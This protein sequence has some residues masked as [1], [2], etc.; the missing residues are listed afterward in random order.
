M[1]KSPNHSYKTSIE[2]KNYLK[3]GT[4]I[5]TCTNEG[6]IQKDTP[7]ISAT[8]AIIYG[9]EG[10]STKI[11]GDGLVISYMIDHIAL[12]E[13]VKVSGH[14]VELGFIIGAKHLVN[15]SLLKEDGTANANVVKATLITISEDSVNSESKYVGAQ[16]KITGIWDGTIDIEGTQTDIKDVKFYI[17]GFIIDVNGV[18][19]LNSNGSS[20][21]A[22]LFSYND[23]SVD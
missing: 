7:L 14:S 9:F 20:S 3:S 5:Q 11:N 4:R 15:G 23:V 1:E 19:Y 12:D 16:F 13:Y 8:N 6:C 2:Y 10:I 18:S 22:H 17:A 21:T